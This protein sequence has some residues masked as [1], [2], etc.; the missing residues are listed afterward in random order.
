MDYL[1]VVLGY[2]CNYFCSHCGNNS[3][4]KNTGS[5]LTSSEVETVKQAIQ[6]NAPKLLLFSGG[7]TTLY[8][9]RINEISAAHP[10]PKNMRLVVVTNGWFGISESKIEDTLGRI[11]H[12]SAVD[13]SFDR[14][15][16]SQTKDE[17]VQRVA[18]YCLKKAIDFK[19]TMSISSP[20]ELIK[21]R[22][23]QDR[24]KVEIQFQ[25]VINSGRARKNSVGFQ[26]FSFDESVLSK[27]CPAKGMI[28]YLP[29]KGFSTCC[30]SLIFN[31]E[32]PG[33]YHQSWQEHLNSRFYQDLQLKTFGELARDRRVDVS[34]FRPQHSLECNACEKIYANA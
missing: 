3:G 18:S 17:Q 9:E 23:M 13:F 7:E 24:L 14:F 33:T 2:K 12:L 21:A 27:K 19:V 10:D 25:R 6:T 20:T 28:S 26:Y 4:P 22:K 16:E 15:H 29:G 11:E 30:S 34:A 5:D 1:N 8:I 32:T 31:R